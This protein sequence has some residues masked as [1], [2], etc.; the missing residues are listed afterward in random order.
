MHAI[1][2]RCPCSLPPAPHPTLAARHGDSS[3]LT[4]PAGL[5]AEEHTSAA[6]REHGSSVADPAGRALGW[7][8]AGVGTPSACAAGTAACTL[9]T[10]A[11]RGDN[12]AAGSPGPRSRLQFEL[13]SPQNYISEAELSS[14]CVCVRVRARAR[15]CVCVQTLPQL[16]EPLGQ[17]RNGGGDPKEGAQVLR[18]VLLQPQGTWELGRQ[19]ARRREGRHTE[20]P[21]VTSN[22]KRKKG[23]K[24]SWNTSVYLLLHLC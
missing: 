14:V 4:V 2:S 5:E 18:L 19:P 10:M 1:P 8:Q 11:G 12:E 15:A 23:G 16:A 13:H 7:Q 21:D 22:K 6:V 3:S 20:L 9:G 17:G 24:I